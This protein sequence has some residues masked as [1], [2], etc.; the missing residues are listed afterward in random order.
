MAEGIKRVPYPEHPNRCQGI[1]NGDQCWFYAMED[2]TNCPVHGGNTQVER[3]KK[4]SLRNYQLT[5]WR[6]KL[7]RHA[8]SSDIKSLRDEIGI[9]RMI[10]EERLNMCEDSMDLILN[11]GPIADLVVKIDKVV[12]NCHRLEGSLGQLLDKTAILQFANEVIN[13]ISSEIEDEHTL[14]RVAH[15]IMHAI[16]DRDVA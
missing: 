11:S 3:R 15:K 9:L 7:E 13:I 4:S 8:G 14:N 16:G 12:V 10:M 6:A 2:A 1:A 5:Q